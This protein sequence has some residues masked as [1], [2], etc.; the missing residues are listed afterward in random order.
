MFRSGKF[1]RVLLI[2]AVV[3]SLVAVVGLG[4]ANAAATLH[5]SSYTG[6]PYTLVTLTGTAFIPHDVIAVGNIT[7][8]GN[9]WNTSSIQIDNC[10]R[11]STTLRIPANAVIGPNTIT[12]RALGGTVVSTTFTVT[13][14][15]VSV[16]PSNGPPY[17]LVT[18]RGS[19]FVPEDTIPVGG[20]KF[21][22]VSWNDAPVLVDGSGSWST[23]LRV[24]ATAPCC[25]GKPIL[26][27]TTAGTVSFTTFTILA[28]VLTI[29]PTSGPIGTRVSLCVSN[30]TP[31]ATI[32]VGGVTIGDIPWNNV[33]LTVGVSGYVCSMVLSV[34]QMLAGTHVISVSDGNLVATKP[35]TVTRPV[36][37]ISPTSGYRSDTIRVTGSGW[38]LQTPNSV[39]ITFSSTTIKEVIPGADGSFALPITV[40]Y[41]A[42]LTSFIGAFDVLG[43]VALSRVFSLKPPSITLTP[44]SGEPGS[45]V[46]LSGIGFQA[47]SGL[48]VFM[49]GNMN[50][51]TAGILTDSAGAFSTTFSVPSL[52][53]GGYPVT[54]RIRG[55]SLSTCFTINQSVAQ[56]SML[57]NPVFP[58]MESLA[59]ISDKLIIIWG[60]TAETG[61]QMYDPKDELGNTLHILTMGRGYW[62][63]V[64][65]DCSLPNRNLI[66]GWNLI[67][68]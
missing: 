49:I 42:M 68:W 36:I 7:F 8:A 45:T 12:V 28:S 13:V 43:N 60:Y 20:I 63:K 1:V 38:P 48:E 5:L 22:G 44:Q 18:V 2:L 46:T 54:V 67:G 4:T 58:L 3:A 62:I 52:T 56:S 21:D 31:G 14:P 37:N 59:G 35:F 26:V 15:P 64:T 65:D 53:T 10:G 66:Q 9:P 33:P 19:N 61:W 57:V 29:S 16:S 40:P 17:T 6:V 23:S 24:P 27:I 39:S 25:G 41:D 51:P 55:E 30:L 34:P 50:L 47:Y 11:W 32:P